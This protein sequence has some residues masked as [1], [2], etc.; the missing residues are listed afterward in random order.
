MRSQVLSLYKLLQRTSQSTFLGDF[1]ALEAAK[2]RIQDEFK[3]NKDVTDPKAIKKLLKTGEDVQLLL[4]TSVAQGI[5]KEN[6]KYSLRI[7]E[8]L[9]REDNAPLPCKKENKDAS[10]TK[11]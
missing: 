6:G 5:H 11:R 3:S 2:L 4:K 10:E 7:H 8:H 9:L 1:K